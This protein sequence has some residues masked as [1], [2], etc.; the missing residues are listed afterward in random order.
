MSR[1]DCATIILVLVLLVILT[2]LIIV[3]KIRQHFIHKQCNYFCF[4]CKY[5][6]ECNIFRGE[7]SL[8]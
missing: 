1:L 4:T 8:L 3:R 7:G 5:K 6:Y 2:I